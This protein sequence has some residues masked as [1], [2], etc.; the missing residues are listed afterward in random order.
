MGLAVVL[1]VVA[2]SLLAVVLWQAVELQVLLQCIR[3]SHG[4]GVVS[5]GGVL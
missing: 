2:Q 3:A 5:R 4:E 1:D